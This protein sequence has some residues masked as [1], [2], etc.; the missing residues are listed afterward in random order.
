MP[1]ARK[2]GYKAK[3]FFAGSPERNSTIMLPEFQEITVMILASS[4]VPIIVFTKKFGII[5]TNL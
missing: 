1:I 2:N 4:I 5:R 3:T